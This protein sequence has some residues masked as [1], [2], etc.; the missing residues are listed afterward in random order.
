MS[1]LIVSVILLTVS[2]FWPHLGY[3]SEVIP[4]MPE[5]PFDRYIIYQS[6]ALFWIFILALIVI[7]WMKLKEIKRVQ[8]MSVDKEDEKV[9]YLD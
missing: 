9:P 4:L 6:L 3:A 8:S 1:F 2:L 7:I 5:R